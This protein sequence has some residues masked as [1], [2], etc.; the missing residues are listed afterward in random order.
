MQAAPD[1]PPGMPA[2]TPAAKCV[3][4][5]SSAPPPSTRSPLERIA[6]ETATPQEGASAAA[7]GSG[8][9]PTP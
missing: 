3:R 6:E 1:L 2:G 4:G 5:A 9:A 7:S 8:G